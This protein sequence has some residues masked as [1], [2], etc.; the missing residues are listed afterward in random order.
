MSNAALSWAFS[1]SLAKSCDKFVLVTLA[2]YCDEQGICYPSHAKLIGDTSLDRKTIISALQRLCDAGLILDTGIRKGV[3][4]QIIVYRLVG[5]AG[6]VCHYTYR[7]YD[8]A[9]GEFY[10]GKRTFD[11]DP[12]A[13]TYRGSG[14][15]VT[16]SRAAGRIL[17]R[18]VIQRFDTAEDALAHEQQL[19]REHGSNPLCRNLNTP[20]Y[21]QNAYKKPENGTVG[22]NGTVPDFPVNGPVFP[23]E[24]SQ[25]S[26]IMPAERSQKRD[27]EPLVSKKER[28]KEPAL[29]PPPFALT[30]S[31]TPPP[32][33]KTSKG[34][35]LPEGWRP[36]AAGER[37]CRDHGLNVERVLAQFTDYWRSKTGAA[38]TKCDW[39]ATWRNWCRNDRNAK[40][41]TIPAALT[42][43]QKIEA[44]LK[45]PAAP[46]AGAF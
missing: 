15:W 7:T 9:T 40:P 33:P 13:D 14:K 42:E 2:N 27:P 11:G 5:V 8:P 24:Q 23:G 19:F 17:V 6:P 20:H 1:A 12:S 41:P 37:F 45:A 28:K 34:T 29:S 36:D 25:I 4:N 43:A 26:R 16:E 18:E 30:A 32:L 46:L 38:A 31:A 22:K 10:F 3:T 21:M 35:R 44:W 39:P